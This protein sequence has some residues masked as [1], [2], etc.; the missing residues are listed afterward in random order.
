MGGYDHSGE[1]HDLAI[2]G[3]YAHIA[4][5]D[6]SDWAN[7]YASL[8]DALEAAEAG[9]DLWVAKGVYYP[10]QRGGTDTD[11]PADSF[12]IPSGVRVWGGFAGDETALVGRNWYLN[13]T[14]L[15]GDLR[16]D[17]T[18]ADGNRVAAGAAQIRGGNSA[19][20]LRTQAANGYTALDG[21]VITAGDAIGEHGGGWLDTGG[22]AP[23][24]GHLLFLGNRADLGGALWSDGAPRITDSA[25]AGNAARQGGAL[26][27]TGAG[28][29]AVPLS[30]GANNAADTGGA[31][32]VD[33]GTAEFA[34]A[35]LWGDGPHEVAVLAGNATFR[36]SL[37]KG[38]GGAAWNGSAGGDGGNNRDTDP[39]YLDA[40]KG[41]LRLGSA[42]SAALN[43]GSN[44]AAL[45]A[46]STTDLGAAP[47]N[48]QGTVDMGAYEQTL[49]SKATAAGTSGPDTIGTQRSNTSVLAGTGDDVIL[50][51]PGR[52]VSTL[53]AGRDVV[54][55][56][57]YPDSDV[58]NDFELGVDRLDLRGVLA[59]VGYTGANP[60]ADG[61]L[62]CDTVTGGA[63]LKLDRDGPGGGAAT[64]Y[65][66]VKGP[67]VR[68]ATL[69]ERAN[70]NF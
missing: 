68:S 42:G 45:G 30:F 28:A 70:F 21:F 5:G 19:H 9:D 16:Q 37:V 23:V 69:C 55:W 50:S 6:G 13:R 57:Y 11:D 34:N 25:F 53:G 32:V 12:V 63:Y 29:T 8:A 10:D 56:L 67:G 59:A 52:Q 47:R 44:A 46:G 51:A 24:L 64:V 27:L 65:A 3:N 15:S 14:V 2:T 4:D 38:A 33:G 41:D 7:A 62:L 17:D 26:Y 22:G 40:A 20:V 36:Y 48:Q 60:L 1:P 43:V 39:L 54:V 31:L 35:V 49:T 61:R 58:I 18:N 66:L